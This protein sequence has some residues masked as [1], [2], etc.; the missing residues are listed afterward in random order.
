MHQAPKG[1]QKLRLNLSHYRCE[2]NKHQC[3]YKK[4]NHRRPGVLEEKT[5]EE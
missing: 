4:Q 1:K 3:C 2:C 5:K